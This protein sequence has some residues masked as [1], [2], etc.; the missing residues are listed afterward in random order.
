MAYVIQTIDADI[1]TTNKPQDCNQLLGGTSIPKNISKY[2]EAKLKFKDRDMK[3]LGLLTMALPSEIYQNFNTHKSAET[4]SPFKLGFHK[5]SQNVNNGQGSPSNL[6][7]ASTPRPAAL[8][9]Q[10]T[11]MGGESYDWSAHGE[12][13][14]QGQ[15]NQE[16]NQELKKSEKL[17]KE[18]IDALNKDI[19]E[20]TDQKNI[21]EI[22]Q[23]DL[24]VKLPSARYELV[25]AKVYIDKFEVSSKTVN[26]ICEKQTQQKVKSGIGYNNVPPSFNGYYT[27]LLDPKIDTSHTPYVS[28]SVDPDV[29]P[30]RD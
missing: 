22:Q 21:L 16:I 28:L 27:C 26:G 8:V 12:D 20:I 29:K 13:V 7:Q 6:H 9:S 5:P 30:S 4:A 15:I 11:N 1:G 25:V 2:T 17:Y 19:T 10:M 14:M 3:A 24:L 18:K 23:E